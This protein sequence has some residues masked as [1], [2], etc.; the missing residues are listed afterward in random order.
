MT[1]EGLGLAQGAELSVRY[2]PT[3]GFTLTSAVTYARSWYSGL[4]GVLRR[5]NY[6]LPL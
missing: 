4:D 6:D 2:K 5:G 3:S 1:S